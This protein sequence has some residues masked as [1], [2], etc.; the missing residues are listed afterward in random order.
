M[1]DKAVF[2]T[3]KVI[4]YH[5]VESIKDVVLC[6]AVLFTIVMNSAVMNY[7]EN[8]QYNCRPIYTNIRDI[9]GLYTRISEISVAYIHEYQ[10][11]V[12]V[13]IVLRVDYLQFLNN[14]NHIDNNNSVLIIEILSTL[15]ARLIY[16]HLYANSLSK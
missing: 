5:N 7:S 2:A 8:L 16:T 3:F 11:S 13:I 14:F 6:F 4:L 1:N 10:I 15:K 9:C 12:D